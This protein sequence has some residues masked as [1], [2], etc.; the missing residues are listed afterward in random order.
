MP[1]FLA[2]MMKQAPSKKRKKD[3][4]LRMLAEV[5]SEKVKEISMVEKVTTYIII[6]IMLFFPLLTLF[7]LLFNR[8]RLDD[9]TFSKRYGNL[10][11]GLS[12]KSAKQYMFNVLF[13]LRRLFFVF[14]I[15]FLARISILQ[16]FV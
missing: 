8:K 11:K 13:L 2:S 1:Y 5:V 4:D 7:A 6:G 10:Y 14:S 16:I 12:T 9:K 3:D 15:M